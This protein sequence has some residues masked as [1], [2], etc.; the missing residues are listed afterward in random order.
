MIKI[1]ICDDEPVITSQIE[2]YTLR[3]FKQENIAIDTEVFYSGKELA[4]N[5]CKGGLYDIIL[6]DIQMEN[7]D[8][9]SSAK[10]I[11]QVDEN[12]LLIYVSSY[13]KYMMDLFR[14]DVFAFVKKPIDDNVFKNT[15][16]EAYAKLCNRRVYFPYHYKSQE[17]KIPCMDI[18]YFESNGRLITIHTKQGK[19]EKFNGKLSEVEEL[20]SAGK[21]S[22]LRIHQSYLVNYHHIHS[23]SKVEVTLVNGEK[24]PI[25]EDRRKSFGMMYGKLLGGELDV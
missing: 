13:D 19:V 6:L 11:R 7:G 24:L 8:G 1:A 3:I 20:L 12:A 15:L 21:I 18:L 10:R 2:N 17:Y 4:D 23:R 5:V 25:S 22:F 14:L 9:I 16:L